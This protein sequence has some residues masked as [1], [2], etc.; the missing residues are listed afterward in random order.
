MSG[1]WSP[2]LLLEAACIWVIVVGGAGL[3]YGNSLET[4][5]DGF[6]ALLVVEC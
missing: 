3:L 4:L 6:S 5:G 2:A 1:C